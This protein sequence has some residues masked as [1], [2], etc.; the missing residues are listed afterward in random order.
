MQKGQGNGLPG[1]LRV[2]LGRGRREIG[3]FLA[4]AA[5]V[6]ILDQASKSWI[7]ANPYP[8]KLLPGFID[9][10]YHENRGAIFGLLINQ[11]FLIIVTIVVLIIIIFLLF[12][13]LFLATIL[14]VV[15]L[16]LLF[17][18]ALGN[19]ID[20]LR[21]GFVIDFIDMHLVDLL[22]W[23]WAFNLADLAIVIGSF[24]LALFLVR[25]ELLRKACEH[26][27]GIRN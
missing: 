18:G 27:R 22:R 25:E 9:L 17:G 26:N 24:A 7:I 2:S 1:K 16:G 5:I 14:T 11:S 12:R 10:V 19:L 8:V 21:F 15:P 20:R 13:Y 3:L 6:V 4:S 23:P